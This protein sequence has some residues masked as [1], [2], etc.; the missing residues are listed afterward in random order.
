[1]TGFDPE[2]SQLMHKLCSFKRERGG[3]LKTYIYIERERGGG[4]GSRD[5][6]VNEEV[7]FEISINQSISI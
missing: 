4:G 2:V 6:V 3:L 5:L 7:A 1:M